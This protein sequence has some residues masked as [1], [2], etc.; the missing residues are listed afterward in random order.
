MTCGTLPSLTALHT[1]IQD[2]ACAL[3][4]GKGLALEALATQAHPAFLAARQ[5]QYLP[6]LQRQIDS[7][8]DPKDHPEHQQKRKHMSNTYHKALISLTY[9]EL[10]EIRTKKTNNAI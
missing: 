10:L 2:A 9:Q 5:D 1:P 4:A 8:S 3:W 6:N 7:K